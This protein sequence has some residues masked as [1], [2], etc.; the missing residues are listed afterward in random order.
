LV[1]CFFLVSAL[2]ITTKPLKNKDETVFQ[3]W[4]TE[5]KRVYSSQDEY[6]LR[7]SIFSDNIIRIAELNRESQI[8][9]GATFNLTKFSD[10][11][12]AEFKAK[13]LNSL[14]F[15]TPDEERELID[16]PDVV[17]GDTYDWKTLGKVT[18]VKNQAQCGSCWAFSATENIESVWMIAKG[19]TAST[20]KPLAP[21]QIVDCDKSDGGCNGG[22]PRTAYS[23]V[24][25]AGGIEPESAYPYKAKN[26]ACSFSKASVYTTISGYKYVTRTKDESQMKTAVATVAPISICVNAAP[27]QSYSKGIMTAK[28]CSNS[29]DH[30]VQITGYDTTSSTPFWN[31]RNSWGTNWG[32]NGYI[33]LEY[34]KN[35]CGLSQE[36]TTAT[37]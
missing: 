2:S 13:F 1:L 27:W 17:V 7:L 28:Q 11:T 30:C 29:L 8:D 33:R 21:Q 35:T 6:N 22:W 10:F 20:M 37:A 32:E 23:Y 19:I 9:G 26:Q 34:G 15:E 12:P 31:V 18:A 5:H 25:S 14:I 3:A 24:V 36:A 4:M 16:L